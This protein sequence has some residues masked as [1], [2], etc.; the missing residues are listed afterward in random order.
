MSFDHLVLQFTEV[1]IGVGGAAWVNIA[2]IFR[3]LAMAFICWVY[4]SNPMVYA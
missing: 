1:S 3:V 4:F 2:R